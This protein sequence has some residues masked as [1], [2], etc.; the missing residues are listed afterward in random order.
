MHDQVVWQIEIMRDYTVVPLQC[1]G[2][3]NA[4]AAS[5]NNAWFKSDHN[6][7]E[8]NQRPLLI[9]IRDTYS[10]SFFGHYKI[11]NILLQAT[12]ESSSNVL[13]SLE[14]TS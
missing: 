9:Q 1:T 7:I 4:P 12:V 3:I 13:S 2:F 10:V 8:N 6:Q 14:V 5:K 11:N